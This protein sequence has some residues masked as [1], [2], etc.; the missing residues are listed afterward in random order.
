[1]AD[2]TKASLE[3]VVFWI[4]SALFTVVMTFFGV[5]ANSLSQNQAKLENEINDLKQPVFSTVENVKNLN[6][7]LNR[8]EGKIDKVLDTYRQR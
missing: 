8:V 1:M 2:E 3:K 7:W 4:M 6:D 5:W